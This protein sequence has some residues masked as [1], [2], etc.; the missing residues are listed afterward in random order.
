MVALLLSACGGGSDGQPASPQRMGPLT[1]AGATVVSGI[2][3]A[4]AIFSGIRGNY[5]ISRGADGYQVVDTTQSDSPRLLPLDTLLAQFADQMVSFDSAGDAGKIYRLYLSAVDHAPTPK[6]LGTQLKRVGGGTALETL[7][8][9][10]MAG[11]EFAALYGSDLSNRSFVSALY[12][13]VLRRSPDES[14]F[15][16]WLTAL[17]GGMT[18]AAVLLAFSDSPEHLAIVA[19]SIE[20]GMDYLAQPAPGSPSRA[21]WATAVTVGNGYACA[22]T[23]LGGVKCWGVNSAGQLGN[24]VRTTFPTAT[25]VDVIGLN[26]GVIAVQAGYQ[27]ACALTAAKQIRC[28]G[29]GNAGQLGD[30]VVHDVSYAS[31]VPVTVVAPLGAAEPSA[32]VALSTGGRHSCMLTE[33][34]EVYCW[35]DNRS[36]ALAAKAL[37]YAWAPIAVVDAAGNKLA[38]VKKIAAGENH[39]CALTR[40]GAVKCFGANTA[41]SL[42]SGK[43]MAVVDVVNVV[44]LSEGYVDI[45]A[46]STHGCALATAGNVKCWGRI[47]KDLGPIPVDVAGF[48]NGIAFGRGGATSQTVCTIAAG[49]MASCWGNNSVGQLGNWSKTSSVTVVTANVDGLKL[50][51]YVSERS[52]TCAVANSGRLMC[53]GGG[54]MGQLGDGQVSPDNP[55]TISIHNVLGFF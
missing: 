6:E 2:S 46:G 7:A 27:H 12:T 31:P 8:A 23:T 53:W 10:F 29:F 36:G 14:G 13:N 33:A 40:A 19:P 52:S 43:T 24:G 42:G 17:E 32:P 16:Y 51:S 9:E 35:G 55:A 25:P 20:L 44:G 18:R 4:T 41:G 3:G 1:H 49:G 15:G 39:T 5:V 47:V 11:A 48:A 21:S 37:Q 54:G 30:G 26:S 22:L 34:G 28:W 45:V 38:G 50:M